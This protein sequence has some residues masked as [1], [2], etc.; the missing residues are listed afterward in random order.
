MT[1]FEPATSSSRTKRA[2]K[3]RHTPMKYSYM[4]IGIDID[5]TI[6]TLPEFFSFLTEHLIKEG[7]EV[8]IITYRLPELLDYTKEQLL[9]YNIRYTELH[10]WPG[11]GDGHI[12]KGKVAKKLDLNIM[13]DN[14]PNNL[15]EMPPT[16]HKIW[17]CNKD[18]IDLK[19]LI[20]S[21]G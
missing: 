12:W 1:G 11:T 8:H 6:T 7:H 14:D 15:A 9:N 19:E 2:T 5:E 3:L 4:R 10:I 20:D 18:E 13:F 17:L 16:T 21:L